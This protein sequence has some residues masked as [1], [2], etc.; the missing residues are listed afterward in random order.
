MAYA[1]DPA[2]LQTRLVTA[3]VLDE[4]LRWRPGPTGRHVVREAHGIDRDGVFSGLYS[5]LRA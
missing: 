1:L 2:L 4:Q 5:A 3:P